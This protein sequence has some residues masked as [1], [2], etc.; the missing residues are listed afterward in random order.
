MH[1][2]PQILARH[3]HEAAVE[4]LSVEYGLLGYVVES[5]VQLGGFRADLVARRGEDVVVFEIKAG[6]WSSGAAEKASGMSDYVARELGGRFRLVLVGVPEPVE[7]EIGE[8]ERVLQGLAEEKVEDQLAGEASHFHSLDV[9]DVEYETVHIHEGRVEVKGSASLSLV[10]QYGS[11][12]DVGRGDGLERNATFPLR[13]HLVLD[14]DM[15]LEETVAFKIE[16][17]YA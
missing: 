5:D 6:P 9:E 16:R 12:G 17:E 8:V 1:I 7:V 10:L 13:F 3:L 11:D 4:Q 15:D 14:Q 2:D